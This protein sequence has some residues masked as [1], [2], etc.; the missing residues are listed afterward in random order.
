[1]P[2]QGCAHARSINEP[3]PVFCDFKQAEFVAQKET[4][5]SANGLTFNAY[6]LAPIQVSG[7][8]CFEGNCM[9]S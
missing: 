4:A 3:F 7:M 8:V 1:M 2:S 6:I 5:A 9:D